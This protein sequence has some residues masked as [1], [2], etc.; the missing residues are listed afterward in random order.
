M[1]LLFQTGIVG[2]TA[3]AAGIVWIFYR[4]IMLIREG[5]QLGGMMIPMLVGCTA[6]LIANATNPYLARFDGLWTLFLPLA[7]INYRLS[8]L[9]S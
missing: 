4:G 7:V 3:Y 6:F 5:G 1:A 9:K 8:L 2:F